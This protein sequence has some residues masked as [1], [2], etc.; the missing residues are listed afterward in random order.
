MTTSILHT[1][2]CASGRFDFNSQAESEIGS[3]DKPIKCVK[4]LP[5]AGKHRHTVAITSTPPG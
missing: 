4:R 5:D 1:M 3:H 2:M